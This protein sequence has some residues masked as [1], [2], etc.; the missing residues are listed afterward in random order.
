MP[1]DAPLHT[2]A[3]LANRYRIVKLLGR[4]GYGAMYRAWNTC[5]TSP[6]AANKTSIMNNRRCGSI[7]VCFDAGYPTPIEFSDFVLPILRLPLSGT[8]VTGV[9]RFHSLFQR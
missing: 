1:I 2:R 5:L 6:C 9:G 3:V 4:G 8:N 7:R